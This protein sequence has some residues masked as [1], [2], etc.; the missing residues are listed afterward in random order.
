MSVLNIN[1]CFNH[2]K[3]RH[4]QLPLFIEQGTAWRGNKTARCKSY[5]ILPNITPMFFYIGL[6][7]TTE[8]PLM[9]M[10]YLESPFR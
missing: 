5:S 2:L 3:W 6:H 7:F 10:H 4:M 8:S 9:N 1:R